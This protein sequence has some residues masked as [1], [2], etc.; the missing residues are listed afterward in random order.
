MPHLYLFGQFVRY[1]SFSFHFCTVRFPLFCCRYLE[2]EEIDGK[3]VPKKDGEI[4]RV[5]SYSIHRLQLPLS[6]RPI[7]ENWPFE[8]T[9]L[10]LDIELNST[11]LRDENGET[12]VT[13]RPSI[14]VW[15]DGFDLCCP[16]PEDGITDLSRN[17]DILLD[18]CSLPRINM[19]GS[20]R[21]GVLYYPVSL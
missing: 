17:Y 10:L 11:V 4:A 20:Y 5:G 2:T 19:P 7:Y 21:D 8:L 1:A 16:I 18:D 14:C 13:L 6:A 12:V 3:V 9:E 15:K